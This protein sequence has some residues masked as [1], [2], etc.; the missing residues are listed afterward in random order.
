MCATATCATPGLPTAAS[1]APPTLPLAASPSPGAPPSTTSPDSSTTPP[2]SLVSPDSSTT[3]PMPAETRSPI[4]GFEVRGPSKV[5]PQTLGYLSHTAIGDLVGPAD[6][7]QLEQ[8][9]LSSELF[10]TVSVSLEP[11]PGDT[12]PGVIVVA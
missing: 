11:A 8:A 4:V 5:K 7:P 3:S 6:V 2:P 9:L 1:A 12:S 10:K